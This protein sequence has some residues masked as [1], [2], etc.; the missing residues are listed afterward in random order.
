MRTH[1]AGTLAACPILERWSVRLEG[2]EIEISLTRKSMNEEE[3][4]VSRGMRTGFVHS[5]R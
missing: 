3:Y 2:D 5:Y 4:L 1:S